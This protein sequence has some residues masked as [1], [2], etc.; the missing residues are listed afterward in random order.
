MLAPA[1][2]AFKGL[3]RMQASS[4]SSCRLSYSL[5]VRPQP[6]LPVNLIEQRIQSEVQNN[7]AAVRA[8]VEA[9]AASREAG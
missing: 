1:V 4:P 3:W 6:W 9:M 5:F 8:H 7:L 2:Q